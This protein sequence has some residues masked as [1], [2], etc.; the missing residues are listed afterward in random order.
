MPIFDTLR[1]NQTHLAKVITAKK[2]NLVVNNV[3]DDNLINNFMD[4]RDYIKNELINRKVL[5]NSTI[6]HTFE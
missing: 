6:V 5:I 2:K 1:I 4:W 3:N